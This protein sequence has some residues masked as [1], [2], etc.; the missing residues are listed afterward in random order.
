M[1]MPEW[2]LASRLGSGPSLSSGKPPDHVVSGLSADEQPHSPS[3][4]SGTQQVQ[5]GSG[6]SLASG[7]LPLTFHPL[8]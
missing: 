3:C 6:W 7:V 1:D 8:S 4:G 2:A 5:L